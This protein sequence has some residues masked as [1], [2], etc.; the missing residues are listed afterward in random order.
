MFKKRKSYLFKTPVILQMESVECGAA[1]LGIILAFHGKHIPLE[2]L[3]VA[4]GVTRD[5]SSAA[6]IANAAQKYGLDF[7]GLQLTVEDLMEDDFFPSIIYWGFNHFV[8]IEGFR[9]NTFYINDPA[10]GRREVSPD[11]F[12][13]RFTGVLL[14]FEP[15]LNFKKSG[16]ETSIFTM[17]S[18]WINGSRKA[19]VFF[20]MTGLFLVFPGIIIPAF[21]KIFVDDI[22]IGQMGLFWSIPLIFGML[23]T[24]F[25]NGTITWLQQYFLLR[26]Q[27]KL[28][29][30]SSSHLIR[31]ILHLPVQFFSQRY[32]GELGSRVAVNNEISA[33]LA[34]NLSRSLLSLFTIA[35]YAAVMFAYSSKLAVTSISLTF[36]NFIILY[37]FSGKIKSRKLQYM[38]ERGKLIGITSSGLSAIESLKSA[39]NENDLVDRYSSAHANSINNEQSLNFYTSVLMFFPQILF[40]VNNVVIL[41]LGSFEIIEGNITMGMLVA[42]QA[43]MGSFYQPVNSLLAMGGQ[44]QEMNGNIK[45]VEDILK[46]PVDKSYDK[47]EIEFNEYIKF[48]SLEFSNVTF[49]YNE[50]SA[51]LFSNLSFSLP[52]RKSI[53]IIGRSGSGKSTVAKLISGL[54]SPWGGDILFNSR[55]I[56]NIPGKLLRN[57][58]AVVDQPPTLFSGTVKEN[59]SM[60]DRTVSDSDIVKACKDACIHD[61]ITK[62]SGNYNHIV[63]EGGKNFSGGE[64]QRM[65]IAR[66]LAKNPSML[67]LDEAT[68]A[69]DPATEKEI[70]NNIEKRNIS[71]VI[72]AHRLSTIRDCNEIIVLDSGNIIERG[73][74]SNLIS[75]NGYY[76][77]EIKTAE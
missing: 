73:K 11:E 51:P 57:A 53:A 26:F 8:V 55:S 29:I 45:R 25:L 48:T 44:I 52:E 17:M 60:W 16:R 30:K 34:N 69:L 68:S 59:I 61:V 18:H 58:V 5:G 75:L 74:H 32:S 27:E 40:N 42:F 15:S 63:E 54:Y 72:I 2:E 19:V 35:F 9:N 77:R 36:V 66:A 76:A 6:N 13:K 22:L 14:A 43:I 12:G 37:H 41:L 64:K 46:Y 24:A 56:K 70:M 23:S 50:N 31:H 7:K 49:G 38:Q 1:S 39:G 47:S 20:V 3:R 65:E 21:S 33:F 28:S 62:K 10:S 71:L 4:C 67:I